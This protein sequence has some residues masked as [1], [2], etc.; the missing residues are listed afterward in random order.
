MHLGINTVR[1]RG[2]GFEVLATQGDTVEV[3]T[4]MVRWDP[5]TISGEDV[6]TLVPVVVMD[7][8]PGSVRV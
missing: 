7:R 4:P 6:S 5:T 8:A 1:L 2:A 3:G